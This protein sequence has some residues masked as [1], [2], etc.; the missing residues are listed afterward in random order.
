MAPRCS[1]G[2]HR[3]FLLQRNLLCLLPEKGVRTVPL[4]AKES[5]TAMTTAS[6]HPY[7]TV[8]GF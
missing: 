4:C 3:L 5:L 2:D 7:H 6:A 8:R 1:L